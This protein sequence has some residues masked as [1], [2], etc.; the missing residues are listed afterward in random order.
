MSSRSGMRAEVGLVPLRDRIRYMQAVRALLVCVVVGYAIGATTALSVYTTLA[1][2]VGYLAL[3]APTLALGRTARANV[4]PIFGGTLLLDGV[5]LAVVT[6]GSNHFDSPLQYAIAVQA[7]AVTL[8]ASFRTG[9]KIAVWHSLLVCV[10]YQFLAAASVGL[11]TGARNSAVALVCV[12]WAVILTTATFG[13]VNEREL[14]QRNLDLQDLARLALALEGAD[15]PESVGETL[16]AF[17]AEALHVDR[18]VFV[19]IDESGYR[20]EASK[21]VTFPL[22]TSGDPADDVTI[23]RALESRRTMQLTHFLPDGDHWLASMMPNAKNV[24]VFP[25]H[26]ESRPVGVLVAEY[27]LRRSAR[28]ERRAVAIVERFVSHAALALANAWL[29][30]QIR[31]QAATDGL[32]GVAN[33]RSLDMAVDREIAHTRRDGSPL[34]FILLDLDHFKR[35]NDDYGHQ[36]GDDALREV[37]AV[38]ARNSR[39]GDLV[40][41][42][43]GEEFAVLLPAT[44]SAVAAHVAERLRAAIEAAPRQPHVTASVGVATVSGG[45]AA[46]ENLIRAADVALYEAKRRGRNQIAVATGAAGLTA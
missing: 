25:M 9:L 43:G 27:G 45:G 13:S 11:T 3:T 10:T 42:Y 14:R 30:I 12:L 34:S 5:Y 29:L 46:G 38:I 41:R 35:L 17:A 19:A 31:A 18:V 7:I 22:A 1:W 20:F 32:T 39:G 26:I 37:A 28:V 4:V 6:Y 21:G 33:R 36:A 23:G 2:S 15:R 40:A 24:L 44:S 8:L 16:V